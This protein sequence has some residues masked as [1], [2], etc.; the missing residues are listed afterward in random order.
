M[1]RQLGIDPVLCSQILRHHHTGTYGD[2]LTEADEQ[3]D[4]GAAGAYGG[5]SVGTYKIA[6]DDGVGG[7]VQLLQQVAQDQGHSKQQKAFGDAALSHATGLRGSCDLCSH[8]SVLS[9]E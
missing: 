4:G 2:A 6:Y 7:V 9:A 5:K 1:H 8:G 3:V